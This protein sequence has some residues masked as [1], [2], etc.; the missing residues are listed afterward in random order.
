MVIHKLSQMGSFHTQYNEDA[1]VVETLNT[2]LTLLAVLDGCSMGTESHFASTLVVKLLRKIAKTISYQIFIEA[3]SMPLKAYLEHCLMLLFKDLNALQ[4]QLLLETEELLTTL[5]LGILD[6]TQ[7]CAEL[8]IIG[9]GLVSCNGHHYEYHQDNR[10]DYLGYHLN[11]PFDQWYA[12][13]TQR[14]SLNQ[15]QDLSLCTDGVC[16]F[17]A[18]DNGHYP[19]LGETA[20]LTQLLCTPTSKNTSNWLWYH[21]HHIE[22]YYGLSPTDDCTILRVLF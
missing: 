6:T 22:S 14:L 15:I 7:Q 3:W 11:Q 5:L 18:F 1:Y 12:Q 19:L 2:Q 10:P 8:L 16:S 21:L 13:Q 17:Q 9:D 20:I 4:Q